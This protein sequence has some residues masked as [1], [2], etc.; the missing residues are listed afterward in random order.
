MNTV[1]FP[2]LGLSFQ[3]KQWAFSIFGFDIAWYAIIIAVG[4]VLACI[5]IFRQV[6]KFG[7]DSDRVVDVI[8]GGMVGGIIGARLYYVIFAW[9]RFKDNI[10]DIFNLR[11]GGLAFYGALIGSIV[12]SLLIC[13]WRGVKIL[14]MLDLA[15]MGFLIGQGIG[16]WGN[17]VNVEA[18]GTQTSPDYLLGMTSSSFK[19]DQGLVHPCFLYE[20]LWCLIGFI[21]LH[22]YIKKRRFDGELALMYLAWNGAGRAVIEGLRDDSLWVGSF[23][24]SQLL[25]VGMMIFAI[26]MILII[27]RRIKQHDDPDYLKRYADTD[28]AKQMLQRKG[29]KAEKAEQIQQDVVPALEQ[30][31]DELTEVSPQSFDVDAILDDTLRKTEH[32]DLDDDTWR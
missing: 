23:R 6:P 24:V 31:P 18:Y 13:K 21:V 22:Q 16:R 1:E 5:Y 20:S 3:V 10:G 12:V 9:D 8:L 27:R 4:F 7:L 26:A 28:D 32:N 25:A 29:G 2:N 14:P 30:Q 19:P 17:F 15:G 11:L